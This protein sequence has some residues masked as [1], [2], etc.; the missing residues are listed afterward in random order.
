MSI[1][2]FNDNKFL[3]VKE[4]RPIDLTEND[5]KIRSIKINYNDNDIDY[6]D[7]D[8]SFIRDQQLNSFNN[9]MKFV[10]HNHNVDNIKINVEDDDEYIRF[11]FKKSLDPF[12]PFQY[13][14]IRIRDDEKYERV[15]HLTPSK[16]WPKITFH[17]DE[18]FKL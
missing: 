9:N 15:S 10:A 6:I 1:N 4:F 12:K 8:F 11:D 5:K 13:K 14:N 18:K 16:E 7:Y 17:V 3:Q 2:R